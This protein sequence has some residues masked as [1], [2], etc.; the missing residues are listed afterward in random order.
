MFPEPANRL[1]F[2]SKWH[3]FAGV[4][5]SDIL[6]ARHSMSSTE[7]NSLPIDESARRRFEQAWRESGSP[8]IEQFLPDAT[9][10]SYAGTLIELVQ[11]DLEMCWKAANAAH[12]ANGGAETLVMPRVESYLSRFPQ[13]KESRL[14]LDLI[15]EEYSLRKRFGQTPP[16]SEY[17]SRFPQVVHTDADLLD[18]EERP[19]GPPIEIPGYAILG[20]LGEGGMGI[21]YLARQLSLNRQ[22]ALKLIS[23][24]PMARAEELAR[25]RAEAEAVAQL[26]DPNI[27]QIYEIGQYAGRPYLALEF[28][29]GESLD[30]R[31]RGKPISTNQA[32]QWSHTLA[33]AMHHVHQR[34]IVHRDLK[35]ANVMVRSDGVL[36]ITDFG[37][38]RQLAESA[39]LTVTGSVIG[40]PSYAPPEQAAGQ[41]R[42]MG[43]A[44]DIYSIGA[45]LY[46]MLTGR[47]PFRGESAAETIL[48]VLREE[49]VSVSRLRPDVS[50]DLATICHKCLQKEPRKRYATA[51]ALAEDLRRFLAD[52]PIAARPVGKVA[53][54]W[55]WAGRNRA[56]AASLAV[57]AVAL[58]AAAIVSTTFAVFQAREARI[59]AQK[60]S[61]TQAALKVA[62]TQ[63]DQ[64]DQL[65][66]ELLLDQA[67]T[68]CQQGD[69]KA[70]ILWMARSLTLNRGGASDLQWAARAQLSSWFR[71][72]TYPRTS[73]MRQ[74]GAI[75]AA[76]LSRDNSLV[77]TASDD[78]TARIWDARTGNPA[79]PP[80]LHRGTIRA[81]DISSDGKTAVTASDD[82]T[83]QLWDTRTGT[84]IGPPLRHNGPVLCAIFRPDG[85]LVATGSADETIRWWDGHTG[86]PKSD[87]L[88]VGARVTSLAFTPDGQTC[89]AASHAGVHLWNVATGA[90]VGQ[91][92]PSSLP[93]TAI[94]ISPDG[95]TLTI[96]SGQFGS[97]MVKSWDIRSGQPRGAPMPHPNRVGAIA[98][99]PDGKILRSGCDDGIARLWDASSGQPIGGPLIADKDFPIRSVAISPD[100]KSC[101]VGSG[102]GSAY[103]WETGT[104]RAIGTG[105]SH[106][107]PVTV[108][109]FGS[110]P[111]ILLTA[112]EDKTARLWSIASGQ[113]APVPDQ[114][115][116]FGSYDQ[117]RTR[118]V[119]VT[120]DGEAVL[121]DAATGKTIGQSIHHD[122]D[123]PFERQV[124]CAALS[125]DGHMILTGGRDQTARLWDAG[126]KPLFAPFKIGA[127]V[128]AVGFAPD[129]R[130][131]ATG[132]DDRLVR[133]WDVATGNPI[134]SPLSNRG[135]VS[136]LAFSPDGRHL[137]TAAT[138][139]Q[140]RVL[141][142]QGRLW[143]IAS[144][145]SI[146]QPM[147]HAGRINAVA[148]SIDGNVAVTVSDDRTAQ[149]WEAATARPI[150]PA[151]SH[152][153]P[154][155]AL[156]FLPDGATLV[157]ACS[158]QPT[159]MPSTVTSSRIGAVPLFAWHVPRAINGDL[160]IWAQVL[161]GLELDNANIVHRLSDGDWTARRNQLEG[162][163]I[164]LPK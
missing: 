56:L 40:T 111:S 143:D 44:G 69:V 22:V 125:P 76:A 130:T 158:P 128:N 150:G 49:P 102:D 73:P 119:K 11:I 1:K 109:A 12:R 115:I 85:N 34:G 126:G 152:P 62:R 118:L 48:Q 77:I 60:Q 98:I 26:Q 59:I 5:N 24:G 35:P 141:H 81:V 52:E 87:F 16:I 114:A 3:R 132:G 151:L 38:A 43:P 27:V 23:A 15:R 134:G 124:I 68:L 104:G 155:T 55:R 46:E 101:V 161:T 83:A 88:Q 112:S 25:F 90:P 160:Q 110:N 164:S 64:A 157:T 78:R 89:A 153:G 97:G 18:D 45:I 29:E 79:S 39:S 50:K 91:P 162:F 127:S 32:A 121:Q 36:K 30:Q 147:R 117:S 148:F 54:L 7:S 80:L 31:M 144:G 106:Q 99:D 33:V 103:V 137:L 116:Q 135:P 9:A 61:D 6:P 21:V 93:V 71:E 120:P 58:L 156:L 74:Q 51:D 149:F 2:E 122:G 131:I 96:A 47:P 129:G 17:R 70:G 154:V 159:T 105:I 20:T 28:V 113:S 107:G 13:L 67:L 108:V 133:V 57:S 14:L 84:A 82:G 146:G 86:N 4:D 37:L 138:Y 75:G 140:D 8:V 95:Q 123:S 142:G 136:A 41:T 19:A 66:S 65:S 63:Q 145:A 92:L 94:A 53:R 42:D 72:I 139:T 10:S 163:G 100:G